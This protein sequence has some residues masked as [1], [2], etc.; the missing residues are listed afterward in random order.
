[1]CQILDDTGR[2]LPKFFQ[3]RRPNKE[4]TFSPALS[5]LAAEAVGLTVKGDDC[6][7]PPFH[8]LADSSGKLKT[9]YQQDRSPSNRPIPLNTLKTYKNS[10]L[11][12][13]IPATCKLQEFLPT[14]PSVK[15]FTSGL[16]MQPLYNLST[17]FE[18]NDQLNSMMTLGE[19][20]L[21]GLYELPQWK[22]PLLVQDQ[23]LGMFGPD[24]LLSDDF[25]PYAVAQKADC[26][27]NT[28]ATAARYKARGVM[29]DS[30]YAYQAVLSVSR[31]PLADSYQFRY[32]MPLPV[33]LEEYPYNKM[34]F[35]TFAS[36][37]KSSSS[38]VY[39]SSFLSTDCED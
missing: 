30:L 5:F 7:P 3:Y 21:D 13:A 25:K 20:I 37:V 17:W 39:L 29:L 26:C 12:G 27:T 35:K 4:G 1:M 32:S 11:R 19:A 28:L 18:P 33:Y 36:L 16:S 15:L 14:D 22:K 9:E 34:L 38:G 8:V 23:R 31:R 6:F 24:G 2:L 10:L